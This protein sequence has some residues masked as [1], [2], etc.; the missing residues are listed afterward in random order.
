MACSICRETQRK[1]TEV[2]VLG[3]ERRIRHRGRGGDWADEGSQN[4]N[5]FFKEAGGKI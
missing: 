2:L 4:A 1:T 3:P 5:E